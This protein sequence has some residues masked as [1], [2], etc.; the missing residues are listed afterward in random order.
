MEAQMRGQGRKVVA[1]KETGIRSGV[2]S[3]GR[4]ERKLGALAGKMRIAA[5]FDETPS[6]VIEAFEGV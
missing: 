2:A 6:E 4:R 3:G 5:D 1:A